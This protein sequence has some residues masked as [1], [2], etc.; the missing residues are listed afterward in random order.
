LTRGYD[1]PI[2]VSDRSWHQSQ[3]HGHQSDA[4][5]W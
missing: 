4:V 1:P 5:L 3:V 2:K